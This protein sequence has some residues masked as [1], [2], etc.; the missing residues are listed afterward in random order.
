MVTQ[1]PRTAPGAP[2]Q[3]T[4]LRKEILHKYMLETQEV[5][6]SPTARN[7]G[8]VPQRSHSVEHCGHVFK[9]T[10]DKRLEVRLLLSKLSQAKTMPVSPV[11]LL[12]L[13]Y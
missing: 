10:L 12:S 2:E 6:N 8:T 4:V 9:T 1:A 11:H 13:P 7:K 3:V 5:W